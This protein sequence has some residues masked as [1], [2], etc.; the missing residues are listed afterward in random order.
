MSTRRAYESNLVGE[1]V[2]KTTSLTVVRQRGEYNAFELP[3]FRQYEVILTHRCLAVY[4][5]RFA[6]EQIVFLF[7]L[8][9]G[10]LSIRLY[11]VNTH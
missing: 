5:G 9:M 11:I 10:N 2:V 8:S 7:V 6:Y 1:F 4:I 3:V